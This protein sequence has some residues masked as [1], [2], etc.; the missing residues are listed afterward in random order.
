TLSTLGVSWDKL[1][2]LVAALS[3]GLGFGLQEI[4]A[5]FISGLI[6]LFERPVRIGDVVTIGNLSGTVS[7]IRIRATTIT[8][9][10]RKE[11]I[12]P[13]KTFVTDQLI[14]WSL[15]DTITRVIV[16][17]G[18]AYESDLALARKLMMQAAE[19]NPRVLR[20]PV[21][22]L[23]FLTISASTFDYELRFH[24]R[25]LGDRNAA[26]DEILTR[27]ALSFREHNV[28]MAFNQVEVMIKNLQG[29]ELNLSSGQ[30]INAGAAAAAKQEQLPP[31][32]SVDP[33]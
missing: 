21:P 4:F 18:L 20:D 31:A 33:L 30:L 15:N 14:N 25:E 26:T 2:W 12:V 16:K 7:K 8:D 24:V 9:F 11:I 23:F 10:D 22:L 17:I 32:P 29:Q 27:I 19:E 28:E 1:Q 5:N 6:I 3:V 13:N